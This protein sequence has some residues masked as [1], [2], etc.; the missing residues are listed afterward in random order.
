MTGSIIPDKPKNK[1]EIPMPI[2][3]YSYF[4]SEYSEYDNYEVKLYRRLRV[5]GGRFKK[6]YLGKYYDAPPEEEIIAE[7]FGPGDYTATSVDP[8]TAEFRSRDLSIA[9]D[10]RYL[11]KPHAAQPTNYD[12]NQSVSNA[13]PMQ[14]DPM[15]YMKDVM[16]GIVTPLMALITKGQGGGNNSA[17]DNMQF[18]NQFME[19]M[20]LN[21]QKS[22]ERIQTT[23][24]DQTISN[25][26]KIQSPPKSLEAPEQEG[27]DWGWVIDLVKQ[28]GSKI[29]DNEGN[30]QQGAFDAV[31]K[32]PMFND[33]INDQQKLDSLYF[34]LAGDPAIGKQ[35]ADSMFT[36]MGVEPVTDEEYQQIINSK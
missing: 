36:N 10:L 35:K 1:D 12:P 17:Q 34:E 32:N 28:F 31:K 19:N 3:Y 24:I 6:E 27:H 23:M 22:F 14:Q 2:D 9:E 25:V 30:V 8:V 16:T 29:F 4:L 15:N 33:A 7:K 18:M 20:T 11:Y 5:T 26:K 13:P 21:Y